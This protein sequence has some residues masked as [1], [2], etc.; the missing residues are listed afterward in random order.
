M[1]IRHLRTSDTWLLMKGGRVLYRGKAS[2]W[3]T[4][5][6]IEAALRRDR[7]TLVA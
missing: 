3:R 6:V 2:P 1:K 4:P 7:L 5:S